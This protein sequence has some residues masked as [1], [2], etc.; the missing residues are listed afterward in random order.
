M[1]HRTASRGGFNTV[2]KS[3]F[4]KGSLSAVLW[5]NVTESTVIALFLKLSDRLGLSERSGDPA[6]LQARGGADTLLVALVSPSALD[7]PQYST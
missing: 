4:V 2:G 3:P 1:S 6:V 7:T 5:R